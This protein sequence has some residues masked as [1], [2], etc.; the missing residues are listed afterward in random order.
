[1]QRLSDLAPFHGQTVSIPRLPVRPDIQRLIPEFELK[2]LRAFHARKFLFA[3]VLLQEFRTDGRHFHGVVT[4]RFGQYLDSKVVRYGVIL[5]SLLKFDESKTDQLAYLQ[6]FYRAMSDS[7]ERKSYAEVVYGCF[8]VC[9]YSIRTGAPLAELIAHA[10]A[11]RLSAGHFQSSAI[12]SAEES[13]LLW[14][15]W[16]KVLWNIGRK[17]YFDAANENTEYVE[18]FIDLGEEFLVENLSWPLW[19]RDAYIE[20]KLKLQFV[21]F[22]IWLDKCGTP[23]SQSIKL[24]ITN[25]FVKSWKRTTISEHVVSAT[26]KLILRKLSQ[27]LWSRLVVLLEQIVPGVPPLCEDLV[28]VIHSILSVVAECPETEHSAMIPQLKRFLETTVYVLILVGLVLCESQ[29]NL[30]I[31]EHEADFALL[32]SLFDVTRG[33]LRSALSKAGQLEDC[34]ILQSFDEASL[35]CYLQHVG[36]GS[37]HAK[38]LSEWIRICC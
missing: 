25:R 1:L 19:M 31:R 2:H 16:E 3:F 26:D 38:A 13:L 32:T 28:G 17:Y 29:G 11:F 23:E 37:G 36:E 22:I 6:Q 9:L 21:R 18:K 15:M 35:D 30:P 10:H 12:L 27:A 34:A 4:R 33:Q 24:S 20:I 8:S 7:V 5:N 14:C